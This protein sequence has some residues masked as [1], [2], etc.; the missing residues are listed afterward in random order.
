MKD[1]EELQFEQANAAINKAVN[2]FVSEI[3]SMFGR[4]KTS[5]LPPTSSRTRYGNRAQKRDDGLKDIF[6]PETLKLL[7]AMDE[8]R[9]QTMKPKLEWVIGDK[10]T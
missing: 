5:S 9:D 4:W 3:A 7:E 1:A 2:R 6:E 10:N 8:Y